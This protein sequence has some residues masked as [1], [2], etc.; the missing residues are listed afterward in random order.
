MENRYVFSEFPIEKIRNQISNLL[1]KS[2]EK[3]IDEGNTIT[4]LIM[5]HGREIYRENFKKVLE[6]DSNSYSDAM[7]FAV[8]KEGI[9]R[10]LSKAGKP[11]ICAWDFSLCT[12]SMSSQDIIQVL[13]HE[14]F[15]EERSEIDTLTLMKGLSFYFKR[16]Y[17]KI[18]EKVSM[19][20]RDL[21]E[22]KDPGSPGAA[23]YEERFADFAKVLKSLEENKFSEL[24]SL[25]HEKIFTIRPESKEIYEENCEKYLVEIVDLRLDYENEMTDIITRNMVKGENLAKNY[26]IMDKEELDLYIKRY[27]E[28]IDDIQNLS[29][30]DYDKY[31]LMKFIYNLYL[32]NEIKLSEIVEFSIILNIETINII[33]N[34]CRVKDISKKM[35]YSKTPDTIEIEEEEVLR[36]GGKKSRRRMVTKGGKT[37]KIRC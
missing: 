11:K 19:N 22:E 18:I 17:P 5:G 27:V 10:I 4:L 29:I 31:Y 20:Y 13:S 35:V 3:R 26:Y 32:G 37:R 8:S 36:L 14:F 34:T 21:P 7:Q 12:E 24:K 23:G 16:L 28:T 1:K 6:K 9:V 30:S 33:D 25:H 2:G 15:S